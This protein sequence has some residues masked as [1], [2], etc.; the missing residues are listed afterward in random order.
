MNGCVNQ[1]LTAGLNTIENSLQTHEDLLKK[2]V[3]FMMSLP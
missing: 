2:A 1:Q 3:S